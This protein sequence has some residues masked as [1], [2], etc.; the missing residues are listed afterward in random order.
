[1]TKPKPTAGPLIAAITGFGTLS[2]QECR[3]ASSN[4]PPLTFPCSLASP[5][6][7]IELNRLMS[8]PA[9][10]PRPAPVRTIARTSSSAAA[11]QIA[12]AVS[13]SIRR[14]QAFNLSGRFNVTVAT[15]SDTS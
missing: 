13:S 10:N 5:L 12:A 1:M 11:L 3:W 7:E 4:A 6:R 14:V 8:A 15:A 9:Q 2:S